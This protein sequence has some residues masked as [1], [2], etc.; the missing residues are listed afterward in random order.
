MLNKSVVLV[1]KDRSASPGADRATT[2]AELSPVNGAI[3][4]S[5]DTTDEKYCQPTKNKMQTWV[6]TPALNPPLGNAS[7]NGAADDRL[8]ANFSA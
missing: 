7:E 4:Q 3:I 6:E 5:I 2:V 8:R 1:P